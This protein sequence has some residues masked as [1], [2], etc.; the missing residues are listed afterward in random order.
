MAWEWK[1]EEINRLFPGSISKRKD[2]QSPANPARPIENPFDFETPR[3]YL[4][5]GEL[6]E[7]FTIGQIA[8]VLG[9]K[10]GTLR[11]WERMG[12]L[13]QAKYLAP[14]PNKDARAK[15]RLYTRAQAE[16]IYRIAVEEGIVGSTKPV[17]STNF[18]ERAEKL[19]N[20][21]NDATD[22]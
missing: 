12:I 13:P 15:R 9:R 8:R 3:K 10:P 17:G 4:I 6:T 21:G 22:N 7:F 20:G 5:S 1:D 18:A 19:F 11:K 14:N 2:F 16:G